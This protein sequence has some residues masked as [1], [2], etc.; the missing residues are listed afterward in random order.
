MEH[1]KG[2]TIKSQYPFECNPC[3]LSKIT[4]ATIKL[5]T[6]EPPKPGEYI[7]IDIWGPA[8]VPS[9][10]KNKYMLSIT[11]KG[12]RY[13][14]VCFMPDR[15]SYF[16]MLQEKVSFI[17]NQTGHQLKR[18][19]LDSAPEFVSEKVKDYV[20]SKGVILEPTTFYTPRTEWCFWKRV[21]A[22]LLRATEHF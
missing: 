14:L 7:T 6:S 12:S 17:E 5:I 3:H 11:D 21:C 15:K 22:R 16:P 9:L 19:R 8:P 20:K 18:L 1:V 10:G 4:R 13:R 2:L